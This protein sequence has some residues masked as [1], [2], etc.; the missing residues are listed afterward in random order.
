MHVYTYIPN[1]LANRFEIFRL[2]VQAAVSRPPQ[3]ITDLGPTVVGSYCAKI[4][5]A[6]KENPTPSHP[7]PDI[8]KI[9]VGVHSQGDP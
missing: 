6:F 3:P 2:L 5:Y 1:P 4:S 8:C 7:A 9:Y